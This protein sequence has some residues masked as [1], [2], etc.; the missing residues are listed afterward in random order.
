MKKIL[1]V[2][3]LFIGS[4]TLFAQTS[5]KTTT[6]APA[7]STIPKSLFDGLHWRNI[8]PFRAGRCIAV[9]GVYNNNQVYYAVLLV[10]AFGKPQMVVLTGIV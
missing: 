6:T 7:I 8:G 1:L 2:L 3:T 10:E 9:T 5:K 4:T